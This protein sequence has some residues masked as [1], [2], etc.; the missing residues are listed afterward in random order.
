MFKNKNLF[1]KGGNKFLIIITL[2]FFLSYIYK[3]LIIKNLVIFKASIPNKIKKA[4]KRNVFPYLY[5]N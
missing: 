5:K 4:I 1:K 3:G 2:I